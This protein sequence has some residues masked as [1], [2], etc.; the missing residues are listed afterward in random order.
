MNEI[1]IDNLTGKQVI[2]ATNRRARPIDNR[3]RHEDKV[4]YKLQ[5]KHS[6][7][8]FCKGNEEETPYEIS[9]IGDE[10]WSVRV[11]K[12]K[13]PTVIEDGDTIKGYHYVVIETP[14]HNK[15]L[16]QYKAEKWRDIFSAYKDAADKCF[17]DNDIK[18]LQI[19]KNYGREGGASLEHPHSQIVALNFTPQ[20]KLMDDN[21]CKVCEEVESELLAV[22]RIILDRDNYIVYAPYGSY[23]QYQIRIAYKKHIGSFEEI[24]SDNGI[25]ELSKLF[26]HVFKIIYISLGDIPLNICYYIYKDSNCCQHFYVDILPRGSF[27]AGF[28]MSTEVYINTIS[29][30]EAANRFREVTAYVQVNK[31]E[32]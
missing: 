8:P 15:K 24:F 26:E 7:C 30:E 29:P 12:N 19:F 3:N 6:D 25:D 2:I 16:C 28:E 23:V 22:E 32:L 5:Y 1:R 20:S 14:N 10:N 11:V 21:Y 18:Y 9:K 17:S 4:N 27:F 31:V 13:Y